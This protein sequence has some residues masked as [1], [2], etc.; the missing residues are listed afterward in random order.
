MFKQRRC[1]YTCLSL[2]SRFDVFIEP[3]PG[4]G[5]RG[6]MVRFAFPNSN[7]GYQQKNERGH[8]EQ[9]SPERGVSYGRDHAKD[10]LD[11]QNTK[12]QSDGLRCVE[13]DLCL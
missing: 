6:N 11:Y 1:Q 4:L 13:A 8:F 7:H 5:Q 9:N 12:V 2:I 10:R 3:L